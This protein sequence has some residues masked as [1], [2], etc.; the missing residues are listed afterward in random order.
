MRLGIEPGSCQDSYL[1][2]TGSVALE[3]P[4]PRR[5]IVGFWYSNELLPLS[6]LSV[7]PGTLLRA[8]SDTELLKLRATALDL[9]L[10][11]RP[12]LASA[13]LVCVA[14]F[15][16]RL[17]LTNAILGTLGGKARVASY[18]IARA[19]HAKAAADERGEIQIEHCRRDIADYLGLN[20]DTLDRIMAE[21]QREGILEMTGRHRIAVRAWDRLR[22][23]T[24]LSDALVEPEDSD[25]SSRPA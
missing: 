4:T 9:L 11:E 23:L 15:V 8:T 14:M 7:F 25:A 5:H 17:V 13:Y 3:F 2:R 19:A 16:R 24:P 21:L 10:A 22:A 12:E 6:H 1:V 20:A 18:I